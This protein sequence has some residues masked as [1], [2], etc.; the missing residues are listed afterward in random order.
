MRRFQRDRQHISYHDDG[1]SVRILPCN[2]MT[3][4]DPLGS[5]RGTLENLT[6]FELPSHYTS[7]ESKDTTQCGADT[8]PNSR[9]L[10]RYKSARDTYI[11][12]RTLQMFV[13]LLDSYDPDSGFT[14]PTVTPEDDEFQRQKNEEVVRAVKETMDRIEQMRGDNVASF[15]EFERKRDE[16]NDIVAKLERSNS[17]DDE[18]DMSDTEI[19]D[20]DVHQQE[21]QLGELAEKRE[22][23]E[24]KLRVVRGRIS[25]IESEND[26]TQRVVNEVRTKTG[27]DPIDWR[28][29]LVSVKETVDAELKEMRERIQELKNS[30][31]FYEGMRELMEELGGVKILESV[32]SGEGHVL[33]LLLLGSHILELNLDKTLCVR[34]AKLLTTT[35]LP[36]PESTQ[37]TANL[38]T[39]LHSISLSNMS[40]SKILS[41]TPSESI[42]IPPLEDL[43][44]YSQSLDS[45]HGIRFVVCET[46]AR[47]RTAQSRVVELAHL[48]RKYAAQIYDIDSSNEQEVVCALKDG[49][50]IALRLGADCPLVKG[51]VYISELC[52]VGGWEEEKLQELK[53]VIGEKRCMGPVEVMEV[54]V[55]EMERRRKEEG[56]VL[57][58]TPE[59]IG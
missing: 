56:W 44:S 58:R 30:S 22:L 32:Q 43:V 4:P 31:E 3:H 19:T 13:E 14:L 52:G 20:E 15:H 1:G 6:N 24:H 48:K 35:S 29:E 8:F 2:I 47:I 38:T 57:P 36:V 21:V 17:T 39:T 51:S 37:D 18:D 34:G 55:D 27:R 41:Q 50:S 53:N 26:E 54:L 5:L 33:Q 9:L 45:S 25:D 49:I 28:S 46:L 42:V 59:R 23:L 40:F 7:K 12:R 16:L 11:H 10:K